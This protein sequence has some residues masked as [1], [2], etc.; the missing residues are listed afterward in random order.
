MN[1]NLVTIFNFVPVPAL[2]SQ[3]VME[4]WNFEFRLVVMMAFPI[5]K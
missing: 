2:K 1:R 4:Q 3:I 5:E